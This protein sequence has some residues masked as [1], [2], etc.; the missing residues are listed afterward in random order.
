ME[1]DERST[2]GLTGGVH[3]MSSLPP[4]AAIP[5]ATLRELSCRLTS[6]GSLQCNHHTHAAYGSLT[7]TSA[8]YVFAR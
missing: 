7:T 6:I 3:S 5:E 2:G 8:G 1:G 4:E